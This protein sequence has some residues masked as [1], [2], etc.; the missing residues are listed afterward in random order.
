LFGVTTLPTV[1]SWSLRLRAEL[2]AADIRARAVARDLT[3]EQLNWRPSPREW[4][5][6]QC[7]D[8]LAVANEVYLPAITRAL[9]DQPPEM[10]AEITPGWLGRWFINNYIE[11]SPNTRRARAPRKIKPAAEVSL[12][13]LDRFLRSNQ[14]IRAF[15]A[16]ASPY[17]VNRIRFVNPF[18]GFVRFTIGTGLEIISR[19]ERRHLLQAERIRAAQAELT[20]G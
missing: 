9:S 15:I 18:V 6:G 8:H 2:D 19:H 4:S 14:D 1:P 3:V 11:P 16:R 12:A 10:V 7:L 20:T 17:N 13:V 5:V